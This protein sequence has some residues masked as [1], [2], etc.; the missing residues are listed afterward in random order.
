MNPG[1][2]GKDH[3]KYEFIQKYNGE[4]NR[5]QKCSKCNIVIHKSLKVSH[6]EMCEICIMR[7]DHHCPWIGKCVGKYNFILFYFFLIFASLFLLNGII[8]FALCIKNNNFLST[9]II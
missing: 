6:C 3:Y 4:I 8:V 2:P 7:Y 1:I 5:L 9:K